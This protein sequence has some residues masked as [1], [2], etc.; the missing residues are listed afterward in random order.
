[1]FLVLITYA[2][3]MEHKTT[4]MKVYGP[5]SMHQTQPAI[6]GKPPKIVCEEPVNGSS[7]AQT[8]HTGKTIQILLCGCMAFLGVAKAFF[9]L[10]SSTPCSITAPLVQI[11][12]ACIS[13]SISMSQ[14]S[15]TAKRCCDPWFPNYPH[16]IQMY[17]GR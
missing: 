13:S 16:S 3:Q 9:A 2:N 17:H 15:G 12:P 8:S 6:A 7:E 5:G 1:M 4:E 10:Q 14:I 11:W